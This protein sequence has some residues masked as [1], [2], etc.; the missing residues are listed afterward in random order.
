MFRI[1]QCPWAACKLGLQ[2]NSS[3]QQFLNKGKRPQLKIQTRKRIRYLLHYFG[4]NSNKNFVWKFFYKKPLQGGRI[5]SIME[6]LCM[7]I[8]YKKNFFRVVGSDRL[9]KNFVWK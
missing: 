9:W 8:F 3:Q 6:K 7:E 5:R 1:S 2:M 4:Q